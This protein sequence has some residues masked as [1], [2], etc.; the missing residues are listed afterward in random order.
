M[1]NDDRWL[2]PDGVEEV[3]PE[4]AWLL[5][6][7]RRDLIDLLSRRGFEL[8]MPPLLEY[9]DALLTG[10]GED[11]DLQT[12][13]LT[14]QLT[15]RL[16]GVRADLTPQVARIDAHYLKTETISRL[17][18]LGPALHTRPDQF[19][20]GRELLQV[21][22]ELFG[23]SEPAADCEILETMVAVLRVSGIE[24]LYLDL[25]HVGVY[26]ALVDR[27]G[28]TASEKREL[29]DAMR[30][31]SGPDVDA[32]LDRSAVNRTAQFRQLLELN[33]DIAVLEHAERVLGGVSDELDQALANLRVVA[34]FVDRA[35]GD[36]PLYIDL[37][38]LRGYRYHTGV[39]FS[40]FVSGQGF[41]VAQGGRYDDIGEA[42][43]RARAATGFS[44]DLRRLAGHP[45]A[46]APIVAPGVA[47]PFD[48]D[49]RL[50]RVINQLRD[51]GERVIY[52][53]PGQHETDL[54]PQCDRKL[55][56]ADGDWS[57]EKLG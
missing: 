49:S 50:S 20:A 7:L 19:G 15:G 28:L 43:G 55:V 2:L 9:L 42:F 31:K 14:D 56:R 5:E 1:T 39:V 29:Y 44:A 53:L 51:S 48:L 34:N 38:E 16:M 37:A 45:R 24:R 22:A 25:G 35:F 21:G 8:V 6:G 54:A 52:L 23:S 46:A 47:A 11:L 36:L 13:K 18:Y 3:L 40:A 10:V 32:V 57:I 26:R 27:A 41:A 4:Q 33:G 12:I 17:C 30:R